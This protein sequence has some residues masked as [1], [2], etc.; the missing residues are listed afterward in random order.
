[1][2]V[3]DNHGSKPSACRFVLIFSC[4]AGFVFADL[5]I[6][7]LI[8]GWE[9]PVALAILVFV[10]VVVVHRRL[11]RPVFHGFGVGFLSG[12]FA[13]ELQA[14]FLPIY[15]ANN[16]EYALI[17]IPFG[18]PARLATAIFAPLNATLAGL[19]TAGIV[20]ILGRLWSRGNTGNAA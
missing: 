19:L 7:G 13:I 4:I 3:S 12:L 9:G 14:L 1:M 8:H 17:E 20:W 18:L 2:S 5:T 16:P 10:G 11:H 6:S 15:F